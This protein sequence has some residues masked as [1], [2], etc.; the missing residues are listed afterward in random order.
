MTDARSPAPREIPGWAAAWRLT[1]GFLRLIDPWL[2][3]SW[4]LGALGITS[5]LE[6]PGRRSG[7]SRSVLVGLLRVDER[8]YIGHPN[9]RAAWTRNLEAAGQAVIRP[10]S[11]IPVRVSATRLELGPE[12]DAAIH[13][14]ARQQPFPGDLLYRASQRHVLAVGVYFRL[15]P[16]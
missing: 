6:V 10:W 2:R 11:T 8:W 15:E 3:V 13:A 9:G 16:T 4:R 7:Q 5:Q 1:Y 14:A 12:R